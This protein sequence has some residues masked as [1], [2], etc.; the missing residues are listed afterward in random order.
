MTNVEATKVMFAG[1]PSSAT[2]VFKPTNE[3]T[4]NPD[5]SKLW[6]V[7]AADTESAII[8]PTYNPDIKDWSYE[9]DAT[10]TWSISATYVDPLGLESDEQFDY[11]GTFTSAVGK[12]NGGQEAV[13]THFPIASEIV[14]LSVYKKPVLEKSWDDYYTNKQDEID[15]KLRNEPI[16]IFYGTTLPYL[17]EDKHELFI[18]RS[19]NG[20]SKNIYVKCD[21]RFGTIDQAT[22]STWDFFCILVYFRKCLFF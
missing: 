22:N 4:P 19:V 13:K 18:E 11:Q 16:E 5:P 7:Y 17:D 1:T 15:F 21:K 12:M 20:Q 8:E 3:V 9:I 6:S 2:Y 10:N 14:K